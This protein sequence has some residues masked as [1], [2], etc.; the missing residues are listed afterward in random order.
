[1]PLSPFSPKAHAFVNRRP[2]HDRFINILTGAVRSGK[3]WAMIP[4]LLACVKYKV[5]GQKVI[6]GQSKQSVYNNVLSDLFDL[7]GKENYTYDSHAGRLFLFGV[8]WVV[9]GASD[10]GSEKKMRG[11]TIGVAYVDEATLIPESAW[12]MLLSRMSPTGARLYATTNPGTPTHYL[13]TKFIDNE[14]LIR[15]GYIWSEQF[16][17]SDNLSLD[18][19]TRDRYEAMFT[20]VFYQRFIKGL[21]VIAEGAVYGGSWDGVHVYKRADEPIGLRN[22]GGYVQRDIAV[23]YGTHN[24]CVFLEVLDDGRDWWVTR[25]Y[26]WDSS[27][28]YRQKTD[29]EYRADLQAFMGQNNAMVIIDPSAA[30]FKVECQ[31]AG[32][33]TV[34]ANNDVLDGIR[35]VS[36]AFANKRVHVCEEGCPN[37]IREHQS[38]SWD[39]KAAKNRGEETPIKAADHTCDAFRY[40]IR[41]T[42]NPYRLAA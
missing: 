23:D 38:Y 25:E 34:D 22:Q 12:N 42:V 16:Q 11:M 40:K 29:A 39:E 15:Q 4:K 21:W 36:T 37:F 7:I 3:T 28:T 20:G 9:I 19:A 24:P 10:E 18:Q 5:R 8:P 2:E 33:V 26:Y 30:S 27:K 31:Q 32:I 35:M 1:M 13:K 14:T 6:V 41:S 17:M